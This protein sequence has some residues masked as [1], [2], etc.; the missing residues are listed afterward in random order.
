REKDLSAAT[1]RHCHGLLSAMLNAAI[2]DGRL[3]RNPCAGV[4]LPTKAG[5][6]EVYLTYEQVDDLMRCIADPDL[7]WGV[8]VHFLAYTGARW[9]EMAGLPLGKLDMLRREVHLHQTLI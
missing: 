4:S 1:V 9:G 2:K 5:G 3:V 6:R 8:I 7:R